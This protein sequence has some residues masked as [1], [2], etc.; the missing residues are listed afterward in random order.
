MFIEVEQ[1]NLCI[2]SKTLAVGYILHSSILVCFDM[3][4]S[5]PRNVNKNVNNILS[6]NV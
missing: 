4:N 6:L 1:W 2:E 5:W 3:L